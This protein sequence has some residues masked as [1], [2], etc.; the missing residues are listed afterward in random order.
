MALNLMKY[1]GAQNYNMLKTFLLFT[2]YSKYV[3]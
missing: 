2:I 3:R 1:N